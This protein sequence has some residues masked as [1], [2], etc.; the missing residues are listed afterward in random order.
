MRGTLVLC[1]LAAVRAVPDWV[2]KLRAQPPYSDYDE[3]EWFIGTIYNEIVDD[4]FDAPSVTLA[5][6]PAL[7]KC[8]L[9]RTLNTL[10]VVGMTAVY[11]AT[12]RNRTDWLAELLARGGDPDARRTAKARGDNDAFPLFVAAQYNYV[13]AARLLVAAGARQAETMNNGQ[14]AISCAALYGHWEIVALLAESRPDLV[15]FVGVDEWTGQSTGTPLVAAA[16]GGEPYAGQIKAQLAMLPPAQRKSANVPMPSEDE[17]DYAKVIWTLVEHGADVNA[18]ETG[19]RTALMVAAMNGKSLIVDALLGEGADPNIVAYDGMAP[20]TWAC[21]KGHEA[22]A[23]VLVNHVSCD[24]DARTSSGGTAA[25]FA[26]YHGK[27]KVLAAVAERS[28]RCDL[29]AVDVSGEAAVHIAAYKK[30]RWPMLTILALNGADIDK[31]DSLGRTPAM[32]AAKNNNARAIEVLAKHGANLTKAVYEPE[33][34]SYTGPHHIALAVRA[35]DALAAL[36]SAGVD[37]CVGGKGFRDVIMPAIDENL[38]DSLQVLVDAGCPVNA[39]QTASDDRG[40]PDIFQPALHAIWFDRVE[41]FR[42]LA[43]A[44]AD[45]D[46]VDNAADVAAD[47]GIAPPSLADVAAVASPGSLKILKEEYGREPS[48]LW[49]VTQSRGEP[50]RFVPV[51]DEN[52]T[53]TL[54]PRGEL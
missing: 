6:Q 11:A 24:C 42:I 23:R 10:E 30:N 27:T 35:L 18:Q 29:D 19:G 32:L 14:A 21:E 20:L 51:D 46:T 52:A 3:C 4:A 43:A 1:A 41:A 45:L 26:T 54:P 49:K 2:S 50:P 8:R 5:R 48:G 38:L 31:G 7:A 37:V 34:D 17:A 47:H 33:T 40:E 13:E 36:V 28:D 22:V 12:I 16:G 15:D 44:G 9:T 25:I 39:T 53:T